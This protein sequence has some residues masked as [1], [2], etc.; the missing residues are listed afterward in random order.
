MV[1]RLLASLAGTVT[2]AIGLVAAATVL[3]TV[4]ALSCSCVSLT[5]TLRPAAVAIIFTGTVS[6]IDL[7]NGATS[8]GLLVHL[9]VEKVYQG[10][11]PADQ[12]LITTAHAESCGYE[13]AIGQR[14][15]IFS[16]PS[17]GGGP[18][19]VSI[20]G[21]VVPGDINPA[22]YGLTARAPGPTSGRSWPWG[23]LTAGLVGALVVGTPI[24]LVA[25]RRAARR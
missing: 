6:K 17:S 21:N 18:L 23:A 14:Y 16:D 4:P 9:V 12:A 13:F 24:L 11:V 7:S 20:C 15:T 10:S 1:R 25:R 8:H 5:P 3:T 22:R 2:A 19:G